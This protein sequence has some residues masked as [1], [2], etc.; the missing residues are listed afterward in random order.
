MKRSES[1][2]HALCQFARFGPLT[3]GATNFRTGW[4]AAAHRPQVAG[5]WPTISFFLHRLHTLTLRIVNY[6]AQ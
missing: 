1:G 3:T 2:H 6:F 4:R 5:A